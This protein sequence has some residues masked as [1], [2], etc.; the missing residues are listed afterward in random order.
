MT[1]SSVVNGL[2]IFLLP[3]D[4]CVFFHL[5]FLGFIMK[6]KTMNLIICDSEMETDLY[7]GATD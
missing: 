6:G 5:Q 2:V 7:K 3:L 4:L 1:L